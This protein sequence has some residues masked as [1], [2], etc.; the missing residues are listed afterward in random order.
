[1]A[2]ETITPQWVADE[3]PIP[4]GM[5]ERFS[6]FIATFGNI[7]NWE[8]YPLDESLRQLWVAKNWPYCERCM[9]HF[10]RKQWD[11][12]DKESPSTGEVPDPTTRL[13]S[14]YTAISAGFSKF[15]L[16]TTGRQTRVL[17][18][19]ALARAIVPKLFSQLA[20]EY[21]GSGRISKLSRQHLHAQ[22]SL[23]DGLSHIAIRKPHTDDAVVS[24]D[25][26]L[27][28]IFRN[29]LW[30]ESEQDVRNPSRTRRE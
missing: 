8:Q 1:M 16:N 19:V 20:H 17:Q 15:T 21:L 27:G 29:S 13:V 14:L 24:E 2:R 25:V 26:P 3:I 7:K 11:L 6:P 4:L 5:D 22:V 12:F 30:S 28:R 18:R 9:I 10:E 23:V